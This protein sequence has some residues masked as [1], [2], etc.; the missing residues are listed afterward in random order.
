VKLI[1]K[2]FPSLK[3][4]Y[5]LKKIEGD[6]EI[7]FESVESWLNYLNLSEY[8]DN[9]LVN[10]VNVMSKVEKLWEIELVTVS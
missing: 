4:K 7:R 2:I 10:N 8:L 6:E 3:I 9:F 5:N 1:S